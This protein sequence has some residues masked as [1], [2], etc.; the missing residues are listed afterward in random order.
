MA[1]FEGNF[2]YTNYHELNLD[3]IIKKV[4]E[5][6]EQVENLN[7]DFSNLE[8][9]FED[10]KTYVETYLT[11]LN[12]R[13]AVESVLDDWLAQG[14]IQQILSGPYMRYDQFNKQYFDGNLVLRTREPY[15]RN[16]VSYS[17]QNGAVYSPTGDYSA[18]VSTNRIYSWLVD[19]TDT[20]SEL[21]T[22][23]MDNNRRDTLTVPG[24]GHG[25][26]IVFKDEKLY[27]M[28]YNHFLTIINLADPDNPIIESQRTVTCESNYLI[29]V[30][31][32]GFIGIKQD[33]TN[34]ILSV[35]QLS[36]N[37]TNETF[38]YELEG[39]LTGLFQDAT[40]DAANNRL[41]WLSYEPNVIHIHNYATGEAISQM[42]IPDIIGYVAAGEAEWIDVK[43]NNMYLAS[44][45]G[46]GTQI[47][48]N[49]DYRVWY[50]TP[51]TMGDNSRRVAVNLAGTR[52][53]SVRYQTADGRN[54]NVTGLG[55]SIVFKYIEDAQL[56]AKAM[57]N[58]A[59]I[60]I[61]E[62]YPESWQLHQNG[63]YVF[64]NNSKTAAFAINNNINCSIRSIGGF[65]GTPNTYDGIPC[66]IVVRE[67]ANVS[68]NNI[69]NLD[70]GTDMLIYSIRAN[71][72]IMTAEQKLHNIAMRAGSI[73]SVAGIGAQFHASGT[74]FDVP[75][76][77][78]TQ[79]ATQFIS[80]TSMLK[81]SLNDGNDPRP[82]YARISSGSLRSPAQF[83]YNP[84]TVSATGYRALE[85]VYCFKGTDGASSLTMGYYN[86]ATSAWTTYTINVNRE[87]ITPRFSELSGTY[88]RYWIS[89]NTLSVTTIGTANLN[90]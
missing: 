44:F 27:C 84:R 88:Y 89:D 43:N 30:N 25:G 67:N 69:T 29:G 46:T 32:S 50:S 39:G 14:I 65:L 11:D 61:N 83:S 90:Q 31:D 24:M 71:L 13:T 37:L 76:I 49:I 75:Y 81:C 18:S 26:P 85:K 79:Y 86:N 48:H 53:I 23:D 21:Q 80:N 73:K 70:V 35:Y 6:G 58:A 45:Q 33:T 2:P 68:F 36:N 7:D 34:H 1:L 72:M 15:E 57:N 55:G 16:G 82:G 62:D 47:D 10:L 63:D 59:V 19:N 4:K 28:N 54:P 17:L 40:I 38:L 41:Y 74:I 51:E 56:C 20:I 87:T 66:W 3:W 78:A 60:N 22:Y 9:K 77:D 64:I 12:V 42:V 5:W 52:L 8:D